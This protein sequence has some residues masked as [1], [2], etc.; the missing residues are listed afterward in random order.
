MLAAVVLLVY[1]LV[2]A[3]AAAADRH[4]VRASARQQI[5]TAADALAV[6]PAVQTGRGRANEPRRE[7]H[8]VRAPDR[9]GQGAGRPRTAR[10][11]GT[12]RGQRR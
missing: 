4:A 8:H 9:L 3:L 1:G 6:Q 5:T 12:D 2:K 7:L 10:G 11:S